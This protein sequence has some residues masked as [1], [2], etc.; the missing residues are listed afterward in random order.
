MENNIYE[1]DNIIQ[2]IFEKAF[3]QLTLDGSEL[4]ATPFDRIKT[5]TFNCS[6]LHE[7]IHKLSTR[8]L[9]RI[10]KYLADNRF[11]KK[12]L[13]AKTKKKLHVQILI[14]S[15]DG[16]TELVDFGYKPDVKCFSLAVLNNRMDILAYLLERSNIKMSNE[17]LMYCAEFGYCEKIYFYLRG[18]GLVP[19]ISVYNKAAIG[20]SI[21][22]IKDISQHIGLSK[23]ILT[24]AFESNHTDIILYLVEQAASEKIKIDQNLMTYP[25]LNNNMVL[26]K[27]LDE[28]GFVQWHQELY[29]SAIL[30][31][32][33]EM[34]SYL[35]NKLPDIHDNYILDTSHTKKG[36]AT[37]LLPDMMYEICGKKYFSHTINYAIQ[38]NSVEI[39]K[40]IHLKGYLIT[41]SNFLTAIKQG[42]IEICEHLCGIYYKPLPFYFIHYFGI[43]SYIPDKLSKARLLVKHGLLLLEPETKLAVDDYR[44]ENAHL[45]MVLQNTQ[46]TENQ[47]TDPDYLMKYRLFFVPVTGHKFNHRLLTKTRLCLE[48]DLTEELANLISSVPM[49]EN[50]CQ[51]IVDALFLFGNAQQIKKIY[52]L[53]SGLIPSKQIIMELLCYCS[54]NKMCYLMGNGLLTPSLVRQIYPVVTM[55]DDPYLNTLFKRTI[56][57]VANAVEPQAKFI[58]MSGK[59]DLIKKVIENA[60]AIDKPVLKEILR[61]EDLEI[62]QKID[63]PY[64]WLNELARW[65]EETDLLEMKAYLE[66]KL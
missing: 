63:I 35:E 18:K 29:Y 3:D 46:I 17:L 54:I 31:G 22:I 43:N 5:K 27:K 66:S 64:H 56:D 26:L 36:Q 39:L 51:I 44:K 32:S 52:P 53:T 48:L 6:S 24:V 62:I 21:E 40:Y 20:N 61:M 7:L 34:V 16:V 2:W 42:S 37:L 12:F 59:K 13:F 25:I 49:H 19:N 10:K 28:M 60:Q 57:P 11:Q 4:Y 41:P 38:S 45:E 30:S 15:L 47:M 9:D 1:Q 58:L 23:K 33:I 8:P 65:C 14:G 50:D 55:L